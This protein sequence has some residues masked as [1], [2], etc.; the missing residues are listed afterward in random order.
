MII[1]FFSKPSLLRSACIPQQARADSIVM[2][3]QMCDNANC[4]GA[5]FAQSGL[6]LSADNTY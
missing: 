5:D 3:L 4:S 2:P 1:L 6:I